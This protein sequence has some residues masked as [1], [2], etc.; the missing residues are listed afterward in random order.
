[1]FFLV[2]PRFENLQALF[3][4][5]HGARGMYASPVI[6]IAS[7]YYKLH[8]GRADHGSLLKLRQESGDD[9]LPFH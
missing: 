5:C 2:V 4:K 6:F 7:F 1:M 9:A 8:L 3:A